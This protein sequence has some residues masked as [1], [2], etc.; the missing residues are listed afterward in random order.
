LSAAITHCGAVSARAAAAS[1]II[2]AAAVISLRSLI[3]SLNE[4]SSLILQNDETISNR[5]CR[6]V[7]ETC[8]AMP[9]YS[10]LHLREQEKN[11]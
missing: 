9:Y 6:M 11:H 5:F 4:N 2:S 3:R 10:G 7:A 8:E 1:Q